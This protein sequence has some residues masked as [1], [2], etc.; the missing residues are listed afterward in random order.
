M[1]HR[2]AVYTVRVHK[3][4]KPD[5]SRLLGDIDERGSR[6]ISALDKYMVVFE[7]VSADESKVVQGLSSAI[8]GDE[9]HLMLQH[10]QRG[11]VADIV[12]PTGELRIHQ[13]AD[14]TQ[15]V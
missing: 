14:D 11:V 13:A 3:F 8:E 9:L 15:R 2:V 1:G 10:G 7:S 6:L 12:D 4:F 5:V